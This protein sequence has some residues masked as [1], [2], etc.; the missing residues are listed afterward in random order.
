MR[1][2]ESFHAGTSRTLSSFQ[3]IIGKP[4]PRSSARFFRVARRCACDATR[5]SGDI[6]L[7]GIGFKPLYRFFFMEGEERSQINNTVTGGF[8]QQLCGRRGVIP[9]EPFARQRRIV[10][11]QVAYASSESPADVVGW[12]I[13][14]TFDDSLADATDRFAGMGNPD[15]MQF[16]CAATLLRIFEEIYISAAAERRFEREIFMS[17]Y[18]FAQLAQ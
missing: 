10:V 16:N 2:G 6:L 7:S 5:A 11:E 18:Q 9:Q 14:P 15:E 8:S 3:M 1:T 17:I 13:V 4:R 12:D